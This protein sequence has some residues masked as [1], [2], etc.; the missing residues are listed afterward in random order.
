M[1]RHDRF[2]MFFIFRVI[3]GRSDFVVMLSVGTWSSQPP[4][5]LPAFQKVLK[6]LVRMKK[7]QFL[8]VMRAPK[9]R[10]FHLKCHYSADMVSTPHHFVEQDSKAAAAVSVVNGNSECIVLFF[11]NSVSRVVQCEAEGRFIILLAFVTFIIHFKCAIDKKKNYFYLLRIDN[12]VVKIV[13]GYMKNNRRTFIVLN[14][15]ELHYIVELTVEGPRANS[16]S[17]PS[18]QHALHR[19]CLLKM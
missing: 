10:Y 9:G 17:P 13:P 5:G 15:E 19:S 1:T 12:I 2:G 16:N 7:T 3:F 18:H 6:L 14:T 8:N 11:S 4:G